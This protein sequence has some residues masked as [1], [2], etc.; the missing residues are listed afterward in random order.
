MV[1]FFVCYTFLMPEEIS[2]R[3]L[4]LNL[5][6]FTWDL[7]IVIVFVG[8]SFLW[9]YT[10][11]KDFLVTMILASYV[12][13]SMMIFIPYLADFELNVALV[14]YELKVLMFVALMLIVSWMM[15]TNGYFEPHI[16]PS[17]WEVPIFVV[18]F[19][20]LIFALAAFFVPEEVVNTFSPITRLLF[21]DDIASTAWLAAPI[22]ILL[23][24]R[25]KA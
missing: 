18:L 20:G 14:N 16:V 25:G 23:F 7:L 2:T 19:S 6:L 22:G 15:A 9:F 3:L 1:C 8:L 5:N 21:F 17:S 4:E 10:K 24:I 12:S 13:S 11:G